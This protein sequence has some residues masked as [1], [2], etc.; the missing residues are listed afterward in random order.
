MDIFDE[1]KKPFPAD[2]IHWRPGKVSNNKGL[3]LAYID[4][5][6]VMERLDSVVGAGNWQNRYPFAGCCD[7][8]ILITGDLIAG[9]WV[10]KSNGAGETNVEGEKGQYSDAFKR[11]AVLWGIGQYLYDL[12][13]QWHPMK[14]KYSFDGMPK[15]PNWALPG[16]KID[17]KVVKEFVSQMSEALSNGDESAVQELWSE[18]TDVEEKTFLWHKFNSQQRT[19]MKTYM[20][21]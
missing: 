17:Q 5:R 16:A 2:K 21:A 18:W 20:K 9:G 15:L 13:T 7:I 14:D 4:A 12:P 8:G 10:W 6:D 3:A 11:A 19:V 1:L